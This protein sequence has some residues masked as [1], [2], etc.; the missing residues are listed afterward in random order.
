[1]EPLGPSNSTGY[2]SRKYFEHNDAGMSGECYLAPESTGDAE[3]DQSYA[4]SA[5]Q[6]IERQWLEYQAWQA[7]LYT[8]Q[9][10]NSQSSPSWYPQYEAGL[11]NAIGGQDT[12]Q[13][14]GFESDQ[15]FE[16]YQGPDLYASA[17]SNYPHLQHAASA[18]LD[19][20]VLDSTQPLY[21]F[22][23]ATQPYPYYDPSIQD[24]NTM[25][26]RR[27]QVAEPSVG[28]RPAENRQRHLEEQVDQ[29]VNVLSTSVNQAM[30][31]S[32]GWTHNSGSTSLDNTRG[33]PSVE[34]SHPSDPLPGSLLARTRHASNPV[35]Y[36][37]QGQAQ[38]SFIP[39]TSLVAGQQSAQEPA[40]AN[41]PAVHGIS[42]RV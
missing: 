38:T 9:F 22:S 1:M 31:R 39:H 42:R 20:Q 3:Q 4:D 14:Q 34:T 5:A 18:A 24:N 27:D 16:S 6:D 23:E 2:D 41:P 32:N 21:N 33:E 28:P 17:S 7:S 29:W 15:A 40:N 26:A 25:P 30:T 12:H 19:D 11:P 13:T 8:D 37:R 35:S 10:G 36:T